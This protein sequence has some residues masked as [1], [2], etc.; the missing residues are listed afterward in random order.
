MPTGEGAYADDTYLK[1]RPVHGHID[2]VVVGPPLEVLL[3]VRVVYRV[4][5]LLVDLR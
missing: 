3:V 5:E 1:L 4:V 2:P